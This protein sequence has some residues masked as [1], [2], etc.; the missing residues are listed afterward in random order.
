MGACTFTAFGARSGMQAWRW[1]EGRTWFSTM[2]GSDSD[3][4]GVMLIW[5]QMRPPSFVLSG[6]SALIG[7]PSSIAR[8]TLCSS[9]LLASL[10]CHSPGMPLDY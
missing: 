4:T 3:M 1:L 6:S 10:A 7:C 8:L 2:L 9:S 5:L